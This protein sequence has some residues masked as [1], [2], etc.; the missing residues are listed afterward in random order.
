MD[1]NRGVLETPPRLTLVELAPVLMTI[2]FQSSCSYVSRFS[3]LRH[4]D[5]D[6]RPEVDQ[7]IVSKMFFRQLV[8]VTPSE[9]VVVMSNVSVSLKRI[10]WVGS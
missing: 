7:H 4:V 8:L 6:V 1:D 3:V 10:C 9:V 5:M 2:L